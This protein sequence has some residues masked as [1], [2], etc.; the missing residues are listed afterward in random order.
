MIYNIGLISVY[1]NAE[2]DGIAVRNYQDSYV[3]SF[4]FI[5]ALSAYSSST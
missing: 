3:V 5:V 4:F 1:K 2:V